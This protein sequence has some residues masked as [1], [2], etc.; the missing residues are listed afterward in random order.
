MTVRLDIDTVT[1]DDDSPRVLNI[2]TMSALNTLCFAGL[3]LG[4]RVSGMGWG[5][6][7]VVGVLGGAV[8]AIA[9]AVV[10][11]ILLPVASQ[12]V[13]QHDRRATDRRSPQPATIAL[14][15]EDA[16]AETSLIDRW[17]RDAA[18]EPHPEQDVAAL[19]LAA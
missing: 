17:E 1:Q 5:W 18:T 10:I 12:R 9:L 2:L 3:T 14:W 7:L 8:A 19:R 11:T 15:T 13:P 6:A 16:R 4:A